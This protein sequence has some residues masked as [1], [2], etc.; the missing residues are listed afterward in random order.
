M[1]RV[2]IKRVRVKKSVSK[3]R[4]KDKMDVLWGKIIKARAD[5]VCEISGKTNYEVQL[6]AHHIVGKKCTA[7]RWDFR[8]GISLWSQRHKLGNPSAHENPIWFVEELKR[9]RPNDY[10]YCKEREHI[11]MPSIPI[12]WYLKVYEWLK[13]EAIKLDID[14]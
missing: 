10:I 6:H 2:N 12:E 11:T 4:L 14:I 13:E 9:I 8:N 7:L 5:Y 1:T 3:S